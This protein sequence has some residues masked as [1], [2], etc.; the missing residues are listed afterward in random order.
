MFAGTKDTSIAVSANV[1]N[2]ALA[3]LTVQGVVNT[4]NVK[5]PKL[6]T[7]ETTGNITDFVVANSV[8]MT[9]ITFAT[10]YLWRYCL[11]LLAV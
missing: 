6:A 2:T 8:T 7:L 1:S 4:L 10:A 9:T 11:L 5:A 3:A